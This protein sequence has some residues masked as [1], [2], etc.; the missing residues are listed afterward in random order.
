VAHHVEAAALAQTVRGARVVFFAHTDLAEE[1]PV[2]APPLLASGLRRAGR[3]LDRVLVQRAHAVAAISE[4]LRARLAPLR[5]DVQFVPIPWPVP[6][7]IRARERAEARLAFGFGQR[8]KLA[9]YA[10]NLDAYQGVTLI[11]HALS[12]LAERRIPVSLLLATGSDPRAFIR[13]CRLLGVSVRTVPLGDERIRRQIHAAADLT[14]VPRLTPGGLPIKLLDALA[15]GVPSAV[16]PTACA[17]LALD[18]V[19]ERAA[20]DGPE[21]LAVAI[22][23][24]LAT[25]ERR[26]ALAKAGRAYIAREHSQARFLSSLDLLL[27]SAT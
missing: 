23:R 4:S 25:P 8:E 26:A 9:L 6:E 5:S 21:A 3:A 20:D 12:V 27:R 16:V 19:V 10:G 13:R 22:E 15:R 24:V 7:P 18:G 1:L 17:G 2:Y 14:I 11:P